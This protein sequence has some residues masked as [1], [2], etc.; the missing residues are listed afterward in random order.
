MFYMYFVLI[1]ICISQTKKIMYF[2]MKE[3]KGINNDDDDETDDMYDEKK[4]F[5]VWLLVSRS[6]LKPV[7]FL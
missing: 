5:D 7:S 2:F 6:Y 1:A 3:I 4:P